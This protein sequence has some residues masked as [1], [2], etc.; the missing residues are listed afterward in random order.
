MIITVTSHK[1]GCGKSMTVIH[2]AAFLTREFGEGS[3]MVV[4]AD[5]NGTALGWQRRS[6]GRLPFPVVSPREAAEAMGRH[7]HT[8]I[9]TQGRPRGEGLARLVDGCDLLVVPSAPP[10]D[11][12]EALML[13]VADLEELGSRAAYGVLLTMVPWWNLDGPRAHRQ[14]KKRGV[15]IF[16]RSVRLRQAFRQAS[17]RGVPV[18]EVDGRGARQGWEDYEAVGREVVS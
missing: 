11:D 16:E 14:L 15:P 4:D 3:T 7:E 18:Y 9:D 17:R 6:K 8:V 12:L 5:P 2:L 10:P 13:M 1:G